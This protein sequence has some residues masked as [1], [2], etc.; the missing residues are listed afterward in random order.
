MDL[1]K[2]NRVNDQSSR[3]TTVIIVVVGALFF[4]ALTFNF[5]FNSHPVGTSLRMKAPNLI[6]AAVVSEAG[7][8]HNEFLH[9]LEKQADPET[10][11]PEQMP[12]VAAINAAL[13]NA[14]NFATSHRA[15]FDATTLASVE[16]EAVRALAKPTDPPHLFVFYQTLADMYAEA[17]SKMDSCGLLTVDAPDAA[18]A[19]EPTNRAAAVNQ[20]MQSHKVAMNTKP[21]GQPIAE[22]DV[23]A[24]N[25][26]T[27]FW[28]NPNIQTVD[29]ARDLGAILKSPRSRE[30]VVIIQDAKRLVGLDACT[31]PPCWPSI[32]DVQRLVCAYNPDFEVKIVHGGLAIYRLATSDPAPAAGAGV[33]APA[34]GAQEAILQPNI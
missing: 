32:R 1:L 9:K 5:A 2:S 18:T 29:V 20:F 22:A 17:N 19:Q 11:L 30:H 12:T 34:A 27:L 6:E 10:P 13:Q 16:T 4:L 28:L 3:S 24:I 7:A 33:A 21:E 15:A 14:R 26:P 23:N 31:A 25:I 8:E